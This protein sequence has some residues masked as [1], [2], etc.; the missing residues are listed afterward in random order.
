MCLGYIQVLNMM[1]YQP[2]VEDYRTHQLN[3]DSSHDKVWIYL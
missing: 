3:Y 1:M 2:K